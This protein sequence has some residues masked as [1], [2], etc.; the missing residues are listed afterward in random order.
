MSDLPS[1]QLPRSIRNKG[2]SSVCTVEAALDSCD[3][4]LKN[5]R[6]YHCRKCYYEAEFSVKMLVGTGLQFEIWGQNGRKSRSHDEIEVQWASADDSAPQ[7]HWVD[8]TPAMYPI[9]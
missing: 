9:S 1:H 2:V 8:E 7:K 3:M 4:K 6:W 5:H